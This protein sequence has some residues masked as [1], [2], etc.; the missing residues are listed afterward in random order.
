MHVNRPADRGS[1][2]P[3]KPA[4]TGARWLARCALAVLAG[5]LLL[6]VAIA[7]PQAAIPAPFSATYSVKYDQRRVGELNMTMRQ[8]PS[9]QAYVLE[10]NTKARR[11]LAR[12]VVGKPTEFS[13]F[14][15]AGDGPQPLEFNADGG[16]RNANGDTHIQFDW[17]GGTATSVY[18]REAP[19]ELSLSHGVLD[20]SLLPVVLMYQFS[21]G[22]ALSQYTTID[23]NQL[24]TYAV[25]VLGRESVETEAGTFEA[26]KLRAQRK[27]S[28]REN[29]YWLAPQ[30]GHLIVQMKQF[31]G[32][33]LKINTVLKVH[34][35]A[36]DAA[37]QASSATKP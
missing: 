5:A 9:S 17:H 3:Q 30:L 28:S 12:M 23:K 18:E 2:C 10:S 22:Q 26:I 29:F 13:R 7:K 27:G 19:V 34:H 14:V 32:E 11:G 8:D 6:G 35:F 31:K 21:N 1:H 37:P 36:A 20:R 25:Q 24:R 4:R 33:Q 15:F 16:K